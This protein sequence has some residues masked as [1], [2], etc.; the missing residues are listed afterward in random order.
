MCVFDESKERVHFFFFHD[1]IPYRRVTLRGGYAYCCYGSFLTLILFLKRAPWLLIFSV[2]FQYSLD[3]S[4]CCCC[5]KV[6]GNRV[7]RKKRNFYL[8]I[9]FM[10]EY[11][12]ASHF[13]RRA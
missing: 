10:A 13:L 4:S 9:F 11:Y 1:A 5:K 7:E 8:F 3:F 12:A 2:S 6:R